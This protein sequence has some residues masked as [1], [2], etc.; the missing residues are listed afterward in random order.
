MLEEDE[1]FGEELCAERGN[2]SAVESVR[3]MD[4]T[5][6][7]HTLRCLRTCPNGAR[8]TARAVRRWTSLFIDTLQIEVFN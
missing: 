7:R 1:D 4:S 3:S 5:N 2:L 6:V 8:R